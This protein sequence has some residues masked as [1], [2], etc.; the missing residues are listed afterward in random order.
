MFL[1]ANFWDDAVAIVESAVVD[2]KLLNFPNTFPLL[3]VVAG[4]ILQLSKKFKVLQ[5]T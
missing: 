5:N 1:A 3:G 2:V 4:L